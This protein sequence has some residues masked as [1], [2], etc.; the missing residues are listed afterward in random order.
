MKIKCYR[1]NSIAVWCY[2]PGD[3]YACDEHVPRGCSCNIKDTGELDEDGNLIPILDEEGNCV[4]ET[5]EHGRLLPCCEWDYNLYGH[6]E[7]D[8]DDYDRFMEQYSE[9]N[10]E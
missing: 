7:F 3:V 2:S 10:D 5:D 9:L 8:E 4:E 6:D 1:C